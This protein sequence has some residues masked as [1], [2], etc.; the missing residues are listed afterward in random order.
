MQLILSGIPIEIQKKDIKNL[1]LSVKPPN[2]KVVISAP[3]TMNDKAIEVFAR[4]KLSWI[5][6]QIKKYEEQPRSSKRQYISGETL[7]I[8][9]KQY[10]LIFEES[11]HK[12][13]FNIQGNKV[14]LSMRS[15]S[16]VKQRENFVREQYRALLQAEIKRLLPRWE[17]VTGLKCD[18]WGTKY[19]VTKW[20]A[21]NT[22][23]KKLW[24]N[25][26]L[27]Q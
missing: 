21:C 16:T 20:G 2:G 14:I 18:S 1:H 19:M 9:G 3:L 5:K 11:R 10:F 15:E 27:A 13:T 8:W 26:Q 6:K 24:F 17:K 23:D 22:E 12:N 25:L 4:T 7:Y